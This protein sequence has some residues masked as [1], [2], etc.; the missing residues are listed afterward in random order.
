M[1]GALQYLSSALRSASIELTFFEIHGKKCYDLLSRRKVVHLRCD[2]NDELHVR[3]AV[4]KHLT[5]HS[6]E[7]FM[8]VVQEALTLRSSEVR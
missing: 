2:E 3:G 7:D 4:S 6:P 1:N 8:T 5:V